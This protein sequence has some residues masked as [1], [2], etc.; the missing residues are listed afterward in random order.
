MVSGSSKRTNG[1]KSLA[2][3][4]LNLGVGLERMTSGNLYGKSHEI[5]QITDITGMSTVAIPQ[6]N[7]MVDGE[8]STLFWAGRILLQ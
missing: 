1:Q 7:R 5:V 3:T 6:T 8:Y 2:A 4:Q